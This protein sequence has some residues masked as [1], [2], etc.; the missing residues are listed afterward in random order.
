M[1]RSVTFVLFILCVFLFTFSLGAIASAFGV[2]TG[3]IIAAGALVG[4]GSGIVF[5]RKVVTKR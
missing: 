4:F 1:S 3:T 2:S 5:A